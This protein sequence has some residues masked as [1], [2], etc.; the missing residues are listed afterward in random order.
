MWPGSD[1][2][3]YEPNRRQSASPG[4][5]RGSGGPAHVHY[6]HAVTR[7]PWPGGTKRGP[8]A[9][10]SVCAKV[11]QLPKG[12]PNGPT[13]GQGWAARPGRQERPPQRR[14]TCSP[15]SSRLLSLCSLLKSW[16]VTGTGSNLRG[17]TLWSKHLPVNV[18]R[19]RD[20]LLIKRMRQRVHAAVLQKTVGPLFLLLT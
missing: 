11:S 2:H 13:T 5:T 7:L 14:G 9:A 6:T 17:V 8:E 16:R 18:G 3:Q 19:T 15:P 4:P 20:P 12:L 10:G 1:T